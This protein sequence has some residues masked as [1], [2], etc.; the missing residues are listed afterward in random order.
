[1]F[2]VVLCSLDA[3][4]AKPEPIN[5]D[6]Y[7][8]NIAKPGMVEAFRKAV[9]CLYFFLFIV[10]LVA[11]IQLGTSRVPYYCCWVNYTCMQNCLYSFV[12]K[13]K[14]C[15]WGVK[16]YWNNGVLFNFEAT[17]LLSNPLLM[18]QTWWG[19]HVSL[20]LYTWQWLNVLI[21]ILLT[22]FMVCTFLKRSWILP[23]VLKSRWIRYRF[24]KSTWF[25]YQ[26]LKS[27]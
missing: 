11:A 5:W 10:N 13:F 26:V 19:L 9:S 3:V 25:L 2:V 16:F 6:Y 8:K 23:V 15:L 18:S 14:L 7:A 1:M 17:L 21:S 4:A 27:P 22:I 12:Y 20:N 24:L